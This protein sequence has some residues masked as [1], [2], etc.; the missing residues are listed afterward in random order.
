MIKRQRTHQKRLT[1]ERYKSDTTIRVPP[2]KL[3]HGHLCAR[4]TIRRNVCCQHAARTIHREHNILTEILARN[5][6]HAP[7]RSRQSETNPY[8]PDDEQNIFHH[9]P[10]RTMRAGEVRQKIRRRDLRQLP[11]P[12]PRCVELQRQQ[13]Q[14][15]QHRKPEPARFGK[16]WSGEVHLFESKV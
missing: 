16:M 14:R 7:L 15:P 13:Q 1:S 2:H 9:A 6:A 4:K 10:R 3:L 12:R 11:S 5:F 8:Q